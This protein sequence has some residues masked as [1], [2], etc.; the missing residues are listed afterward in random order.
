MFHFQHPKDE[1]APHGQNNAF[2]YDGIKKS[3]E[4]GSNIKLFCQLIVNYREICF[5]L[6]GYKWFLEP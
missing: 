3:E 1:I 4:Q 5:T 6:G 2:D